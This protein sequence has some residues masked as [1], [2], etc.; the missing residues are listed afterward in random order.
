MFDEYFTP[1]PSAASLVLAVLAPE[2]ADSTDTPSLTTM[3]QDAPSTNTSQTSQE[4]QSPLIPSEPNSEESSSRDVIPTNVHLVNQ[5][6]EYLRKWTKDH[7][8]DNVIGSLIGV[9]STL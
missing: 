5:P 8:L 1:P 9:N 4:S 2:P 7:P 3:D 6:H